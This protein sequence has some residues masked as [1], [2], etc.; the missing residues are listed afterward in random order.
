M[1]NNTIHLILDE[2]SAMHLQHEQYFIIGGYLIDN[3]NYIRSKCQKIEK[4]LRINNKYI[5]ELK[6]IKGVKLK[7]EHLVNYISYIY[8]NSKSFIPVSILIDK[9]KLNKKKWNENE[10]FNFLLNIY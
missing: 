9:T 1:N 3:I 2:T 4:N 5:S 6:E 10:A 7:N 8:K